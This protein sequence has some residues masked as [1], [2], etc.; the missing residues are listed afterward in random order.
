MSRSSLNG[1]DTRCIRM[2]GVI[3][4]YQNKGQSH[5]SLLPKLLNYCNCGRFVHYYFIL[6]DDTDE[7]HYHF[8]LI[9]AATTR[10]NTILNGMADVLGIDVIQI[11][12]EKLTNLNAKLRYFLHLEESAEKKRYNVD[13][14]YSDE[15]I[16]RL[17]DYINTDDDILSS[18]RLFQLVLT[19]QN[20]IDLMHYLG[21]SVY[22]KYRYEIKTLL[23]NSSYLALHYKHLVP[24]FK[25]NKDLPFDE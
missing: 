17:E 6:H 9:L 2:C 1:L 19:Y 13:N 14:I 10:L 22:H 18:E 24:T 8:I 4:I 20:E 23:E 12:I 21:L 11:G 16:T 5:S 7:L 25:Q 3:T 15:S